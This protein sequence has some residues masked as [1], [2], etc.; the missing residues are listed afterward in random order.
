[1]LH[2]A[3]HDPLAQALAAMRFQ[4]KHVADVRNRRKVADDPGKGDLRAAPI[5]NAKAQGVLDGSRHGLPRNSFR[6]IR[7]RQEVVDDVQVT[8]RRVSADQELATTVLD[9]VTG[10]S[11]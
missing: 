7:V 11:N 9:D 10:C 3:L 4:H 6:P 2:D 5:I 8:A 1:M